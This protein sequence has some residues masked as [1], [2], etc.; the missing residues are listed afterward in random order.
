MM[1]SPV[2]KR[3]SIGKHIVDSLHRSILSCPIKHGEKL[4]EQRELAQQFGASLTSD[5]EAISVLAATDVISVIPRA[6]RH[7]SASATPS[8]PSAGGWASP[9]TTAEMNNFLEVRELLEAHIVRKNAHDSQAKDFGAITEALK[10]LKRKRKNPKAYL[11]EDLAFHRL[12]AS[13]SGS[14]ILEKLLL[15][16]QTPMTGSGRVSD[17]GRGSCLLR[18]VRP[19]AQEVART[20]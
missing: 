5:R 13:Y 7:R 19:S 2:N 14:K 10:R 20:K 16:I 12:L 4:P 9:V 3:S 11:V 15:A 18:R 8:R 6:R 17:I 1:F